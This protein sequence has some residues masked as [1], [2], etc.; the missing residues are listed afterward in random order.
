VSLGLRHG[1]GYD[2]DDWVCLR[3]CETD[4]D[5]SHIY[6]CQDFISNI[7]SFNLCYLRSLPPF[8]MTP[9]S[10]SLATETRVLGYCVA[11]FA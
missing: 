1:Y 2:G 3:K 10:R 9:S 11:L 8:G 6:V 4:K 7:T 5:T